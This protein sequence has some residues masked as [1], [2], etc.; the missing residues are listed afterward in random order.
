MAG[1][2]PQASWVVSHPI[3]GFLVE[4]NDDSAEFAAVA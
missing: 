3:G 2:L 1:I 4:K